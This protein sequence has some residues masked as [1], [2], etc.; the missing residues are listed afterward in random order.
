MKIIKLK[1]RGVDDWNR[2]VFKDI[3]SKD[4]FG[5]TCTLFEWDTPKEDIIKHF[6][7]TQEPLE[8]FGPY[9]GCEPHGGIPKNLKLEIL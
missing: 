6:K 1:F 2:P 3:E 9:F 4:H 8:Y 7:E 5:S